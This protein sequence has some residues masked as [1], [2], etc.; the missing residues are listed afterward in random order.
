MYSPRPGSRKS[1]DNQSKSRQWNFELR[2]A[3]CELEKQEFLNSK[4]AIR[5]SQFSSPLRE[6]ESL[7]RALLSVLLAFLDPR[8]ARDQARMFQGR[9]HVAVVLNQSSGNSV[10]NRAGL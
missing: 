1:R 10:T 5:N 8:I 2:I 7:A 3:N 6:L 9:P 4:S